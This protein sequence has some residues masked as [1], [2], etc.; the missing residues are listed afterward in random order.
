VE[1]LRTGS[2]RDIR[3]W[4]DSGT[5][6]AP[7]YGDDGRFDTVAARDA[8]LENGYQEGADFR[9]YLADGA[10]HSE[11]AWAARLPLIFQFLFPIKEEEIGK[12]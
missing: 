3:L 7:D 12:W 2:S 10:I 5:R 9:Y 8:L 11:A 6:D 1:R 4:L